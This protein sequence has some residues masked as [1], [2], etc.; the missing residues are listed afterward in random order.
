MSSIEKLIN[1]LHYLSVVDLTSVCH[2][3]KRVCYY[4]NL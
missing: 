2:G 4:V 1:G 3:N